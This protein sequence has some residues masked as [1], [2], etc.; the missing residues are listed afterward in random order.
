MVRFNTV[1]VGFSN[2]AAVL[3]RLAD[4]TAPAGVTDPAPG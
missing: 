1:Q 2:G 3:E 4:G